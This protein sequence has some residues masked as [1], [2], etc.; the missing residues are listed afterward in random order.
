MN[1]VQEFLRGPWLPRPSR[2][3]TY[4]AIRSAAT[5]TVDY[6]DR[7]SVITWLFVFALGV[8]QL[9]SLPTTVISLRALGSP[10]SIA[11]TKTLVAALVLAIFA[12]AGVESVIRAHPRF[13]TESRWGWA[14]PFGALPMAIAII[15]VYVLP[16]A[17]NRPMQA[18][19]LLASGGL[20][21]L[22]LFS[23]Y[24]TIERGQSGFRR[25]R[26]VLDALSYGA[27]LV[28]FLFVY[29][30]RTRSLLSGTL[31]ALTATLLAIELLRSTTDRPLNVLT[32]GVLTGMILGQVT[33]ALNYWWTIS[34]L[35]GGLLLLLIF[36]I[37]VGIA[38]H[39]LQDQLNRRVL[40]EF[41]FFA[42]V[43]LILIMAVAPRLG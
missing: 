23:L 36:Y 10:V 37:I 24:T 21:I 42:I 40:L 39:G 4:S 9:Y 7:I 32:Y 17:P 31:V 14:W 13:L 35:T 2:M 19:M 11:L 38:Q 27:A 43:A 34:S 25:S 16:L 26:L 28:L 33:W 22:A 18:L 20:M 15:A 29:Q 41:A 5:L 30:T 8:S 6:R 3:P 12:A 1:R